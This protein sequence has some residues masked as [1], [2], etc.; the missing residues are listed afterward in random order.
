M[1]QGFF[2]LWQ[3]V[4]SLELLFELSGSDCLVMCLGRCYAPSEVSIT[5]AASEVGL[6]CSEGRAAKIKLLNAVQAFPCPVLCWVL[7]ALFLVINSQLI[8]AKAKHPFCRLVSET[9]MP[10][11]SILHAPKML[12][13]VYTLLN[14]GT[15]QSHEKTFSFP[16]MQQVAVQ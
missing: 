16:A 5:Y 10:V 9:S 8:S 3:L 7:L 15:A 14:G 13:S 2:F 6:L 4:I 11:V 1:R 12:R